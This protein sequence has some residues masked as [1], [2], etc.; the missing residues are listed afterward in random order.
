MLKVKTLKLLKFGTGNLNLVAISNR[1]KLISTKIVVGWL[2][3]FIW[4]CN[5]ENAPD[6]FQNSG[7][8]VRMEI[9]VPDFSRI[10]V[11]EKVALILKEGTEQK[12]EIESG[13][14]LIEGVS[15]EVQEGR[16][17][18]RNDNG[19][20]LLREYDLTK[21][22][23]TSPNITEIRSSSGLPVISEGALGYPSLMLISESYVNT[24][25]ETTDG[26]F[27]LQ[28]ASENVSI[29]VNGITY[30]KLAGTTENLNI[31][32]AAGDSRIEAESLVAQNIILNHRGTNDVLINP[33]LSLSG[34]IRGTGDVIS[35]SRPPEINVEE[36]FNGRLIFK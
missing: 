19:C 35:V 13:E 15:A 32:I 16:L 5:S 1:H 18:L 3:L 4:G 21:V 10:T 34:V 24:E 28:L 20:N 17:L 14:F 36:L 27:D 8:I 12:V 2:S 29:V 22:Y 11:F 31:N 9:A 6:C 26:E 7:D 25:S 33:Q 23:I 30:F